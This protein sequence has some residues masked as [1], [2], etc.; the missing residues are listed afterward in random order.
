MVEVRVVVVDPIYPENLGYIA[1]A[2]GN[3]E[4]ESLVRVR[5]CEVTGKA[6]ERATHSIPVLEASRRV[7]TLDEALEGVGL[8]V[9]ATARRTDDPKAHHRET[10]T[11]EELRER[12]QEVEGTVAIVLGRE[13]K[14]LDNE[15]LARCDLAVAIP[16][17]GKRSL[18]I[19]HAAAVLLYVLR[20]QGEGRRLEE[21]EGR[22]LAGHPELS[23]LHAAF[24]QLLD[25]I[26]HPDH[27]RFRAASMFR[28]LVGRAAPS[29]WEFHRLM[30]VLTQ[31][32]RRLGE[33]FEEE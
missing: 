15:E 21:I 10:L 11:P 20:A 22:P 28:R 13:D 5:G 8:A 24:E 16:A 1:R 3:F 23:R 29:T 33:P 7:E 14:G 4:G 26:D 19:G 25:A 18:N 17:P 12:L 6:R 32:L 2:I 27:Q 31:T 30:G 9:G